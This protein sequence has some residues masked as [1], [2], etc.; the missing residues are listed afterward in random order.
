MQLSISVDIETE[1]IYIMIENS[2]RD[3]DA[4]REAL[5]SPDKCGYTLEY[6]C[7]LREPRLLETLIPAIRE[8]LEDRD[9]YARETA[10]DAIHTI[11]K[12]FEFL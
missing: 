10:L 9:S 12:N 8:C 11:Y 1:E 3:C 2:D 5:E 4:C 7:N 6:L